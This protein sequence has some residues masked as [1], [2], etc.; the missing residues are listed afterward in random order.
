MKK[1]IPFIVSFL[2]FLTSNLYAQLPFADEIHD[3]KK[4]DSQQVAKHVILFTGSSSIRMW[5]NLKES[6]PTYNVLNRGFGGSTLEDL[7]RYL[8]DIVFP[9]EPKQILIYSGEN[10][11]ATD[12]ISAEQV[13]NRFQTVFQKI[14]SRFP[15][16]PV[17]YISIKPSPSRL[18]FLPVI[19]EANELIRNYLRGQSNT[20]FIDVFTMMIDGNGQPKKDIFLEDNLH[21]NS[22]GYAIWQ[23]VIQ[24]YLLK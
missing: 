13:L 17:E 21:M 2:L 18:K 3:F 24:P 6:F 10:D 12:T 7:D 23:G 15:T 11:I 20:H 14:R 16:V 9:Y 5:Q 22:K 4:M 1:Q 8:T 19:K